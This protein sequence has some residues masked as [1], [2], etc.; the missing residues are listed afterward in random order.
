MS[1]ANASR[2]GDSWLGTLYDG[3]GELPVSI[4]LTTQGLQ[5]ALALFVRH[6]IAAQA[7]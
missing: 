5:H 4:Q 6:L 3:T 2:Y 1:G 7:F